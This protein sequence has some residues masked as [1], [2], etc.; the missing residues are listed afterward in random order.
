MRKQQQNQSPQCRQAIDSP[1]G[2]PHC[3]LKL[4]PIKLLQPKEIASRLQKSLGWVYAHAGELG[5][6]KIGGSYI[7]TEEGLEDA[8]QRGKLL[9]ALPGHADLKTTDR[10]IR[11][12]RASMHGKMNEID[13]ILEVDDEKDRCTYFDL[14]VLSAFS[15]QIAELQLRHLLL[16]GPAEMV[17][18]DGS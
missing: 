12:L 14:V 16:Y 8:I 2:K 11:R 18:V 3:A 5:A 9:Q 7:F 6:S 1:L 10:Y 17:P 13:H 4:V 15:L